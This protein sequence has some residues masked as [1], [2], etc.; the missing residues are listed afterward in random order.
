MG[1]LHMKTLDKMRFIQDKGFSYE[2]IW[3]CQFDQC[4]VN[5]DL[6]SIIVTSEIVSPLEPRDAFFGGR[7]EAFTLFSKADRER[8]INYY[9]VTSLYP[10]INKTGKVPLGHPEIKTDAFTDIE[11]YE[12][13]IKCKILPKKETYIPVLLYKSNGK[14]ML[15]LCRACTEFKQQMPYN[16]SDEQHAITGMWVTDEVKRAIEKGYQILQIYEV[17]HFQE[18]A[19]YDPITKS[20]GMFTDYINKFLKIKQEANGLP[21]WCKTDD[22]K[23]KYIQDYYDRKGIWLNANNIKKNPGLRQL[24]KLMLNSFWEKF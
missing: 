20:G 2:S 11:N 22:D 17:W 5:E 9:D 7:T 23:R 8:K 18:V 21:K 10:F 12:G 4:K 3:E 16:Q 13:L 15:G 24:A 19:Q 1:D 6:K 14:L